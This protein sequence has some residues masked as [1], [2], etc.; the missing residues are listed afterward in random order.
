MKDS[1]SGFSIAELMVAIFILSTVT[2]ALF[3]GLHTAD[4]IRGRANVN[5]TAST[6]AFSEAERIRNAAYHGRK[7]ED[8]TYFSTVRGVKFKISRNILDDAEEISEHDKPVELEIIVE[9]EKDNFPT[10]TF[11]MIQ[12]T[13]NGY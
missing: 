10:H 2:F 1:S 11:K 13:D 9:P 4:R 8:S 3:H 12:G 6:L 7:L 5:K